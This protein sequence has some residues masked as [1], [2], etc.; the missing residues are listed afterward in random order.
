MPFT[1]VLIVVRGWEVGEARSLEALKRAN[2]AKC[3]VSKMCLFGGLA[4]K[5]GD[6]AGRGTWSCEGETTVVKSIV[7]KKP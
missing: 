2:G 5:K 3:L 4:S 1:R 7:K 6:A